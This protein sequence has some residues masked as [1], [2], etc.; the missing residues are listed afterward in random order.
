MPKFIINNPND[1]TFAGLMRRAC[2][3]IRAKDEKEIAKVK[4]EFAEADIN[5]FYN[6]ERDELR[7]L[8]VDCPPV[9]FPVSQFTD[10]GSTKPVGKVG[11]VE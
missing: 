10:I 5:L 1:E 3:A 8:R 7:V 4:A 11:E 9:D 6:E 2:D